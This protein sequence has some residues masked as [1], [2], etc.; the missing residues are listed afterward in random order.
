MR[1]CCIFHIF[2]GKSSCKRNNCI[3]C[4]QFIRPWWNHNELRMGFWRWKQHEHN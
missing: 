2:A 1:D 3:Q 4:F